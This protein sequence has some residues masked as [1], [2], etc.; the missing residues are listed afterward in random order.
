MGR[1]RFLW[2][3]LRR[4]C[5]AR[6][7]RGSRTASSLGRIRNTRGR[8]RL[9]VSSLVFVVDVWKG[10]GWEFWAEGETDCGAGRINCLKQVPAMSNCVGYP[11]IGKMWYGLLGVGTDALGRVSVYGMFLFELCELR[12]CFGM[13]NV[14]GRRGW[15]IADCNIMKNFDIWRLKRS[16]Y[17]HRGFIERAVS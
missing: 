15:G 12:G 6:W 7:W 3:C 16:D 4:R 11:A 2:F 17:P 14:W 13:R 10:T 9:Q 5:R 8:V 1:C